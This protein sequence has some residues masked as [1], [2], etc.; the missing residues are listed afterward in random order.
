MRTAIVAVLVATAAVVATGC[1]SGGTLGPKSLA[2]Q[3]EAVQS[4]A[5]E[6]ALLAGD[7]AAGRSTRTFSR[8]HSAELAKAAATVETSLESARAE[9]ALQPELRRLRTLARQVRSALTRLGATPQED[10]RALGRRLEAAAKA[11]E[12]IGEELG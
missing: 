8:E 3:S 9:P 4:L 2:K 6:G 7:V 5:A 11:S 1:G 12:K 10:Q